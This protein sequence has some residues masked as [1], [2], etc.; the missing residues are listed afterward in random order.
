MP[1]LKLLKET[2]LINNRRLKSS[3]SVC[4]LD[5]F[6]SKSKSK[7]KVQKSRVPTQTFAVLLPLTR[8]AISLPCLS[9]WSSTCEAFLPGAHVKAQEASQLT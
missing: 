3:E 9:L 2:G 6:D 7:K 5:S 1:S 8:K 4:R